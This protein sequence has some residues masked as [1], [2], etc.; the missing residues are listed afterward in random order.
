MLGYKY[1]DAIHEWDS[2]NTNSKWESRVGSL[3]YFY[4]IYFDIA[5]YNVL[6]MGKINIQRCLGMNVQGGNKS[7]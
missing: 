4:S 3:F 7:N 5:E 1:K 2:C 6:K